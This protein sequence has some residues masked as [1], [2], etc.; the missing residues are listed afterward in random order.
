MF[1]ATHFNGFMQ[2]QSDLYLYGVKQAKWRDGKGDVVGDFI[3]SCRKAGIKPGIH[4]S[5]HRDV[6]REL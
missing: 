4:F 1:T 3:E 2:W 6:Y 5:T